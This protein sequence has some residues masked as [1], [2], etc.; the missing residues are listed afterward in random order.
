MAWIGL[1]A[2][3]I[4]VMLTLSAIGAERN[5]RHS[6]ERGGTGKR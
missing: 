4:A 2:L 3:L 6:L 5:F 1:L